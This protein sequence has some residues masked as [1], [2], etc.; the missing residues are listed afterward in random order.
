M[1]FPGEIEDRFHN[2]EVQLGDQL[3]VVKAMLLSL[4]EKLVEQ[5]QEL[6]RQY[7]RLLSSV[8][9]VRQKSGGANSGSS[10]GL[11][12]PYSSSSPS[13]SSSSYSNQVSR[14]GTT[15]QATYT[16]DLSDDD[17]E[18]GGNDSPVVNAKSGLVGPRS[19]E[20]SRYNSTV[21]IEGGRR[22]FSY[23]WI[24]TGMSYKLNNW[25]QRRS[26]RSNSFHIYP[27]GYRMYMKII[28]R[29]TASAMYVHVGI[30]KVFPNAP[31][32]CGTFMT[33]IHNALLFLLCRASLMTPLDGLSRI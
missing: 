11:E 10:S 19:D 32:S 2:M 25:N 29:Y 21:H 24:I 4:E 30:T 22:V 6:K 33:S 12:Q 20:I 8:G 27:G 18:D 7:R 15:T 23:Y 3:N 5:D 13:S 31:S 17:D 26:L 28:P 9:G 14:R 1:A 16:E